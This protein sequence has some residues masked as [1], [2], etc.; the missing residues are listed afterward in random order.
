MPDLRKLAEAATPGPWA[1][2][3]VRTR[4]DAWKDTAC[5][6]V[7]SETANDDVAAL[8]AGGGSENML[9]ARADAAWIAAAN[10]Q[11]IIALLDE[12]DALRE[13][14]GVIAMASGMPLP[15][16]AGV[17]MSINKDAKMVLKATKE[18]ND[19]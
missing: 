19:G 6:R 4:M 5:F 12:R 7:Y 18:S 11:A 2:S 17:L 9:L 14:L 16:P 1:L 10:P 3:G 15:N 8:P 13:V